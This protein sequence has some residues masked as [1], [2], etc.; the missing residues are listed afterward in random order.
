MCRDVQQK[1]TRATINVCAQSMSMLVLH[2]PRNRTARMILSV[3]SDWAVQL[4]L[5][6]FFF[7]QLLDFIDFGA[8]YRLPQNGAR[9]RAEGGIRI[10]RKRHYHSVVS[11][12][13]RTVARAAAHERASSSADPRA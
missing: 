3:F 2:A 1:Y 11:L 9:E 6:C 7:F 8:I 4:T 13:S 12:V 5:G 10:R